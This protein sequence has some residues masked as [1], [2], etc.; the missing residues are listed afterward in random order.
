LQNHGRL[1]QSIQH[2][3]RSDGGYYPF[4]QGP[5]FLGSEG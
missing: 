5:Q 1:L 2:T 3:H 4:T